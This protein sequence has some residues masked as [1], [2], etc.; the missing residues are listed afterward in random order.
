MK[1]D[2]ESMKSNQPKDKG[3]KGKSYTSDFRGVYSRAGK[4]NAQIQHNGHK[5]YLGSF[6]SEEAAARAYDI[7]AKKY[8]GTRAITNYDYDDDNNII[9]Y[10]PSTTNTTNTTTAATTDSADTNATA[11]EDNNN[12][13]NVN[14]GVDIEYNNN[15]SSL[16]TMND[17]PIPNTLELSPPSIHSTN[18]NKQ[19]QQIQLNTPQ[20]QQMQQDKIDQDN[21]IRNMTMSIPKP[22]SN[23]DIP[24]NS[25]GGF[26]YILY[27]KF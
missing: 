3:S 21:N 19:M 11:A 23:V 9:N 26:E 22:D 13:V 7:A 2:N 4:W 8:H 1:F 16:A 24:F 27:N 14:I 6:T 15:D 18:N 17:I 25:P 10:K 12:N 20:K 5:K